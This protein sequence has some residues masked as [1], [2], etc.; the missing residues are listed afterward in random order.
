MIIKLKLL[1]CV[2]NKNLISQLTSRRII[3]A[4]YYRTYISKILFKKQS[5]KQ[6]GDGS[7]LTCIK[8]NK[9]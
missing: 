6:L 8:S 7:K 2:E 1:V 9:T 3:K 4:L 5:D